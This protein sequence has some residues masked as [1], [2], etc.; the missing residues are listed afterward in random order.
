MAP[1]DDQGAAGLLPIEVG[2]ERK[3]VPVLPMAYADNWAARLSAALAS[4]A[5][6]AAQDLSARNDGEAAAREALLLRL[7][8]LSNERALELVLEFDR[9]GA[10]GGRAWLLEHAS[11]GQLKRALAA[12]KDECLPFAEEMTLATMLTEVVLSRSPSS[13]NGRSPVGVP[14]RTSSGSAS[15]TASSGSSGRRASSASR[16]KR[17]SG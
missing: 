9:K 2:D 11:P 16:G 6:E 17:A 14:S 7:N 4:V 12:M 13:S 5:D 8:R 1:N 3:L 10:L 15:P